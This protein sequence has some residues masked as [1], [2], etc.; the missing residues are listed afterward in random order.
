VPAFLV[1]LVV[2]LKTLL[3]FF[4]ASASLFEERLFLPDWV[5][6]L[7][8]GWLRSSKQ[9]DSG[10]SLSASFLSLLRSFFFWQ[11]SLKSWDYLL[12]I[13]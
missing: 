7:S 6:S 5:E 4:G 1:L 3:I 8:P 9:M 11:L 13:T 10:F 2:I 12:P